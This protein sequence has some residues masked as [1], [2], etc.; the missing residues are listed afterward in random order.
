MWPHFC[1]QPYFL[2]RQSSYFTWSHAHKK[3]KEKT[4]YLQASKHVETRKKAK[5]QWYCFSWPG[6]AMHLVKGDTFQ[7][8]ACYSS[9][10]ILC[11]HVCPMSLSGFSGPPGAGGCSGGAAWRGKRAEAGRS[12]TGGGPFPPPLR[13]FCDPNL[14]I[15]NTFKFN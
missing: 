11:C 9:T 3:Q 7:Y 1:S 10:T 5:F 8:H 14:Q 12:R 2:L 15:K 13:L 6:F 4:F